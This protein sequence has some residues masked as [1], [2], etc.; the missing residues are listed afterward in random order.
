MIL[1]YLKVWKHLSSSGF[2]EIKI[3]SNNHVRAEVTDLRFYKKSVIDGKLEF[4]S[5]TFRARHLFLNDNYIVR[6][7]EPKQ[8]RARQIWIGTTSSHFLCTSCSVH[9]LSQIKKEVH[10]PL[11]LPCIFHRV[12]TCKHMAVATQQLINYGV[13]LMPA[14]QLVIHVTLTEQ[15]CTCKSKVPC[16][17]LTIQLGWY[18]SLDLVLKPTEMANLSPESVAHNIST[19]KWL[20][21][22]I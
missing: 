22:D 2:V 18:L 15:Y 8:I 11:R 16:R 14:P 13:K 20:S 4:K 1:N 19:S 10:L 7:G 3:Y 21:A 5:L 17:C 6:H 12:R 9:S